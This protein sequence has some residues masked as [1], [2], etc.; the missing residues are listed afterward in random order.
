MCPD[1]RL[2]DLRVV[3][4]DA[5]NLESRVVMALQY[6]REVNERAGKELRVAGVNTSLS[7]P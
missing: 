5:E 3:G 2:W 4:V 1:L 6:V 7:I